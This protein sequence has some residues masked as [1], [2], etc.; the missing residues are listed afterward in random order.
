MDLEN[1]NFVPVEKV[2]LIRVDNKI[3]GYTN[4]EKDAIKILDWYRS[5]L[6][7]STFSYENLKK[8]IYI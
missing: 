1:I 2:F 7:Y 5:K 3:M 4:S 6:N 8:I